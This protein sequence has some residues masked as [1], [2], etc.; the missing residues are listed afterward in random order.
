MVTTEVLALAIVCGA[1]YGLGGLVMLHGAQRLASERKAHAR[2]LARLH[3]EAEKRALD[4]AR[5][6][7]MR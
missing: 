5:A 2:T 1:I 6:R 3:A 7:Y 4:I